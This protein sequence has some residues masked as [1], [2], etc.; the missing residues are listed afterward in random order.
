MEG[1][2]V[3]ILDI[4]SRAAVREVTQ[5]AILLHQ[6]RLSVC[7]F[8]L[9]SVTIRCSKRLNTAVPAAHGLAVSRCSA[10]VPVL[11]V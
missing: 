5:N 7:L 10:I 1:Y 4:L 3:I 8:V 9:L 6:F 11:R 2:I